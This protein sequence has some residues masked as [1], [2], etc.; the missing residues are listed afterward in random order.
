MMTNNLRP[1]S[2]NFSSANGS[3]ETSC[4]S[5]AGQRS[6]T[7]L[8]FTETLLPTTP[9]GTPK[10][11]AVTPCIKLKFSPPSVQTSLRKAIDFKVW[12]TSG[13]I[14]D[15]DAR[16]LRLPHLNM[17]PK[18][19]NKK[20][21]HCMELASSNTEFQDDIRAMYCSVVAASSHDE[22]NWLL[23]S[24]MI[25]NTNQFGKRS[26]VFKIPL[27][28]SDGRARVFY[29]CGP[30]FC[31]LFGLGT[32][33]FYKLL[34]RRSQSLDDGGEAAMYRWN[35][36][37]DAY[38]LGNTSYKAFRSDGWIEYMLKHGGYNV[39]DKLH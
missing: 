39:G 30:Q 5:P 25:P 13:K 16:V 11:N 17:F 32:K 7:T 21:C 27:F 14:S 34:R 35:D 22:G 1:R 29:V 9:I 36:N 4:C 18:S 2:L 3:G 31:K 8:N 19:R 10:G 12:K 20:T 37:L 26:F 28:M 23:M 38:I 6:T 33:R 15:T 24:Y